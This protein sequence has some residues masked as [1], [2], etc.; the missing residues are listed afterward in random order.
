MGKQL[1][2]HAVLKFCILEDLHISGGDLVLEAF[3]VRVFILDEHEIGLFFL[4][5]QLQLLLS[6][7]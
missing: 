7:I 1:W 2:V 5:G 6:L 4:L 3:L